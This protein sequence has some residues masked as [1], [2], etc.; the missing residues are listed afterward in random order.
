MKTWGEIKNEALGLMFSNVSGSAKVPTT[1]AE[2]QEYVINMADAAN[3]AIRDLSA[4]VPILRFHPFTIAEE[5][6]PEEVPPEDGGEDTPTDT[7][8]EP[9][10]T[11]KIV[12]NPVPMTTAGGKHWYLMPTLAA[13]FRTFA[14]RSEEMYA[15]GMT[16]QGAYLIVPETFVGTVMIPYYAYAPVITADTADNDLLDML[17]ECEDLIPVYMAS[18]LYM[19]DDVQLATMY[20]NQYEAKRDALAANADMGKSGTFMSTTGWW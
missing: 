16:T 20:R 4:A 9:T 5:L 2:V 13:S 11:Q 17:P 15:A 19:E 10:E 1:A 7:T 8:T 18:R 3:Y 14:E 6:P 12:Q